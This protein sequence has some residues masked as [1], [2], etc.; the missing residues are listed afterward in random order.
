LA[1]SPG[2]RRALPSKAAVRHD[3]PNRQPTRVAPPCSE[4][5]VMSA[6]YR[7]A[8]SLSMVGAAPKRGGSTPRPSGERRPAVNSAVDRAF[9]QL[10]GEVGPAHLCPALGP[11]AGAA[12]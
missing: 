3:G 2:A 6:P 10:D 4:D 12:H 9:G 8:Q 5:A 7:G 1:I 11:L